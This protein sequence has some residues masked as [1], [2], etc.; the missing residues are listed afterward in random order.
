[1]VS[2]FSIIVKAGG[3]KQDVFVTYLR[4]LFVFNSFFILFIFNNLT[5]VPRFCA[6]CHI[7]EILLIFGLI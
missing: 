6:I 1:M 5:T 2:I 7:V 3:K 4:N